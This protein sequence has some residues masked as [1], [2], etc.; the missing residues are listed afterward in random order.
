MLQ[1]FGIYQSWTAICTCHNTVRIVWGYSM[2]LSCTAGLMA[3][4]GFLWW[5]IYPKKVKTQWVW[6]MMLHSQ[7]LHTLIY[8]DCKWQPQ[9]F[10]TLLHRKTGTSVRVY[11][12]MNPPKN[13]TIQGQFSLTEHVCS[14]FYQPYLL[15]PLKR[16]IHTRQQ[17]INLNSGT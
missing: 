2:Y 15:M 12:L 9:Y 1:V 14:S 11:A 10:R 5:R 4:P 13:C 6:I 17:K 3:E 8:Q 16:D 7:M